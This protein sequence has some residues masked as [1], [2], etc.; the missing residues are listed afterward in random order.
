MR[1]RG[2]YLIIVGPDGAGKST[3]AAALM[4]SDG[5]SRTSLPMHW[6]PEFLPRLG[7]LVG[8]APGDPSTP[9]ARPPRPALLSSLFLAYYWIDFFLGSWLKIRPLVRRGEVV[10]MERGW[11]DFAVDP[12]RYRLSVS[13]AVVRLV[14]W[15]LPRPD[16][17]LVL[18]APDETLLRRK[19]E[20]PG[21]ELRRQMHL[22]RDFRFPGRTRK[23]VI[24]AARPLRE[25]VR[26]ARGA[27]EHLRGIPMEASQRWAALPPKGRP[28]WFLPS[29][30]RAAARSALLVYHPVTLRARIGWEMGR[31]LAALGALRFV[32]AASP[33]EAIS[34][35]IEPIVPPG[36][37]IAVARANHPAR[38]VVLV[39]DRVGAPHAFAKVA[40]DDAGVLALWKDSHAVQQL[41]GLLPPP[42]F[43]PEILH[44]SDG[45][46]VFEAVDW[47]PRATPWKLPEPVAHALG[48]VF[49]ATRSEPGPRGAGHGDL[50]PWNLLR[51][52]RGWALI[53]WEDARSDLPP[54]FDVFHFAV[55]A[56]IDLHLPSKPAILRGLDLEGWVGDAIRAYARGADISPEDARPC[57]R[58]YLRVS[59]EALDPSV[60]DH[61]AGLRTRQRLA[62]MMSR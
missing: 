1:R 21:P 46:L 62:V 17:V 45:V 18:D 61:R 52:R 40:L 14:G 33:P 10:V 49:A 58:D 39:L 53:D 44:A 6:R 32:P 48:R 55:Q 28:R 43:A 41:A 50:A 25:V 34:K 35:L 27:V 37:T 54:F 60:S 29:S 23:V 31:G 20:L 26:E 3:I 12:R 56:N 15:L 8:R 47:R 7:S 38:F 16:L 22:W 57:F 11:F 30:S 4:N 2:L 42:V 51:S 59:S 24:D 19:K 13:P 9:H 36:G 5:R